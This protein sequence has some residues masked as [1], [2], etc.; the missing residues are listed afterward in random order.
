MA[1]EKLGHHAA[2]ELGSRLA[3]MEA[4]ATVADYAALF[5]DLTA[6]SPTELELRLTAGQSLVFC[7]GHVKVPVLPS[8]ETDWSR[9]TK[10]RFVSLEVIDG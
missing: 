5:G 6:R 2:V 1:I 7:A 10:I 9:V 3:D 4:L 8:R